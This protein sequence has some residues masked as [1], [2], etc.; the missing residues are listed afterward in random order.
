MKSASKITWPTIIRRTAA[1]RNT[2]AK[3]TLIVRGRVAIQSLQSADENARL[4]EIS[5][6]YRPRIVR[7]VTFP[8]ANGETSAQ[9]I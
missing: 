9:F 5:A 2:L 8:Q 4:R 6:A 7:Q 3:M 1:R